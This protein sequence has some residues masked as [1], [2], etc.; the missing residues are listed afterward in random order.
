MT[1][2]ATPPYT[3]GN[4]IL[5]KP[6]FLSLRLAAKLSLS[7]MLVVLIG[8]SSDTSSDSS[9]DSNVDS[10]SENESASNV[11]NS[12]VSVLENAADVQA[13]ADSETDLATSDD[14]D[15]KDDAN[16]D[17]APVISAR[18]YSSDANIYRSGND[19]IDQ[20]VEALLL[21]MTVAERVG[22]LNQY[23]GSWDVT[24]PIAAS[25]TVNAKRL[26][27]L[28]SGGVGSML[29]VLS[30]AATTEAQRIA[31]EQSRL[32]IP[33]LFA[34]DVIHGYQT[35]FPVPLGEAA[36]WDLKLI[37]KNARIAAIEASAAGVHWTF[38]PMVD[39]GRD[40]R[41]GRVMEGAGEDPFFG[42]QVAVA[43]INGFQGDDLSQPDTI[44]ACAKHFAGYAFAE[45]GRDYNTV[46][47][48]DSTLRNVILPPFKAAAEAGVATFMNAFNDH[49]GVPATGSA[50]LQN[51]I[52][53][54]DWDYRGLII[55]DW[56]SISEMIAHGY[57]ADLKDAA[58]QAINAG[59]D[60]DME[61]SAYIEHLIDLVNS[62]VVSELTL[63]NAVRR[64]L[65]LKHR[66]GLFEDPYRYSDLAR[67]QSDIANASHMEAA[68]DAARQSIVLLKNENQLLPLK[69]AGQSIAVIGPL[70]NDKDNPL[71]NWRAKAIS[72]S[73]VSLLE[74]INA[75]V[76]DT[77]L[78]SYA[79]GA[80]L[81]IE[82]RAFHSEITINNDDTSGFN[83]AVSLAQNA[84]VV[85]LVIGE[86]AY[87]SGEA[88]S[89]VSI[90]LAGV[91][92]ALFDTVYAANPNVVV[93][94][95]N[96]RPLAIE[97]LAN[98]A[99]AI[100][101][102]WH[103]GSQAG[104]G[105][106]DVLFGAYNPSGKLPMSFPR[107][108]G[109]VPIYYNQKN[110]GRPGPSDAVFWSHYTDSPN[111]PLYPFGYGLSYTQFDYSDITVEQDSIS[112]SD[113]VKVSLTLTNSGDRDGAEVIQ[114][115]IRDRVA[116]ITRPLKELKGFEKV[117]LK[118]GESSQVTFTLG[119][120]T[121]GFY[122][123]DG[124]YTVEAGD[125]DIFV[126]GDSQTLKQTNLTLVK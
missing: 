86:D 53:K 68:R 17:Q 77:K 85:V 69:T 99:A 16:Q 21:K 125:F 12:A 29:N 113:S 64:V 63:D 4:N 70:A 8:C 101:E 112:V 84:D 121:L 42:A 18:S 74:G 90:E 5:F 96:G 35:M 37:E 93:V 115:Y 32:G 51:E 33:L 41:F 87:Q 55:S 30:V 10:S 88:R 20:Q 23:N 114:L 6:V 14:A 13:D 118:A 108:V 48:S 97:S 75:A 122:G 109:Q 100:V 15:A 25:D 89:Q 44:A 50:Y 28:R 95:M 9:S 22:Q 1:S 71:G 52:L 27:D 94:L 123:S 54:S 2:H 26:E 102:A 104:H 106:A 105:I 107:S 47:V 76:E 36:S 72:N 80:K 61:S 82:G 19:D 81:A 110:T 98:K 40:A 38:A 39:V 103:A 124:L 78:V 7:L 59:N 92:Q 56:G 111:S 66:M 60:I 34:Y 83:Q 11:E 116:S 126:G 79:E 73:A 45:S 67:E 65:T 46:D 3:D 31:V 49:N 24:G 119:P 91:Q 43:R 62:D 117:M 57:S 58:Q 120:K